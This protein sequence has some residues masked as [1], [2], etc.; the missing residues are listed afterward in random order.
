MQITCID[1]SNGKLFYVHDFLAELSNFEAI[2]AVYLPV[3]YQKTYGS[4][5]EHF[6]G[7]KIESESKIDSE[8]QLNIVFSDINNLTTVKYHKHTLVYPI[9]SSNDLGIYRNIITHQDLDINQIIRVEITEDGS[10]I[11][12]P[13]PRWAMD[14]LCRKINDQPLHNISF[15]IS[16]GPTIED[17][18]PVRYLTNRSS[19]KMG[20]ALARAAYML[21]A[22]VKLT[23]G[24]GA[25]EPPNYLNVLKIRSAEDMYE[26][27][28]NNFNQCKVYIGS[29]AI[30]DFAPV[31]IQPDKIKKKDGMPELILKPTKDILEKIKHIKKNQ[32]VIGFSVETRNTIENSKS[33][34]ID[35]D[36]DL[37]VINNPKE[38]GAAF[39]GDTNVVTIIFKDGRIVSWP[40]M[41]KIDVANKLMN[42]IEKLLT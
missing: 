34:L 40:I 41:S 28:M 24:S 26:A 9:I 4:L 5:F 32:L 39:D 42:E 35:K 25:M 29:A 23:L 33:K 1:K 8:D 30:A 14:M 10:S 6:P 7:I 3:D 38:K 17:I 37:V 13:S 15:L 21:G 27:V 31:A 22:N 19:G 36:L 18:D 20:I 11:Y 16:A 12:T 2:V